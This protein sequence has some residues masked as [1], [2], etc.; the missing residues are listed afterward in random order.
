[1]ILL[2]AEYENAQASA[3]DPSPKPRTFHIEVFFKFTTLQKLPP[4]VRKAPSVICETVWQIHL[5]KDRQASCPLK[6]PRN[7]CPNSPEP[8]R[9]E[10]NLIGLGFRVASSCDF[11]VEQDLQQSSTQDAT[12]V[13]NELELAIGWHGRKT[14][15]SKLRP[16]IER[17]L[18]KGA[19]AQTR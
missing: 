19:H 15:A 17:P 8:S 5:P 7:T 16:L 10:S 13:L 6:K 18:C 4:L 1:M 12:Q 11:T 2:Q 3:I 14:V 9:Q